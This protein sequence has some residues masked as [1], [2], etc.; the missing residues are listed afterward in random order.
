[1]SESI[2]PDVLHEVSRTL[3]SADRQAYEESIQYSEDRIG[4]HMTREMVMVSET[5]TIQQTIEE[6]RTLAELPP[7]TDRIF[8][9]DARHVLRGPSTR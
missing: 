9:V 8:V 4:H 5:T 2:P 3:A 1:V 7:Q 6:L